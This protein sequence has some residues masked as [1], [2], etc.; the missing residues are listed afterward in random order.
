MAT[1]P[2]TSNHEL[3]LV[4]PIG[5]DNASDFEDIWGSVLNDEGWS[6]LDEK[7]VVRDTFANKD[8]YTAYDGALYWATDEGQP[9]LEGDGGSW[10]VIS[11]E[12]STVVADFLD[13]DDVEATT[14]TVESEPTDSTDA[15]RKAETDALQSELDSL[16]VDKLDESDY[17]PEAD[18]HDRYT[19]SEARTAVDGATVDIA[20]Q[21]DSTQSDL[22]SHTS[23]S[24][25]H[26]GSASEDW[27]SS[28]FNDYAD[29]DA[30]SAVDGATV[31][32]AGQADS[33]QS[34]LD[35]HTSDSNPHSGSASEDWVSSNFNDYTDSEARSALED[36]SPSFDG[37]EVS[38]RFAAGIGDAGRAYAFSLEDNRDGATFYMNTDFVDSGDGFEFRFHDDDSS[39]RN[40]IKF[41]PDDES[42]DIP[43]G[44]LEE[45]G[46]RVATRT[47]T[48]SNFNNYTDSD[49]RS[50]V[51]GA[52]IDIA[53]QADSTQSD[54]DSHTS[55]SN[56]HS[57]SASESWVSSNFNDYTD[58]K[59][60][61]AAPIQTVNGETGDVTVEGFSGSHN[62]LSNVDPADHHEVFEPSDYNPEADTHDRYT[63]SEARTAVDG[64]TID[65]TGEASSTQSD[66]DSHTSDSNPHSGSASESWVSSNFN[67]YADSEAVSAVESESSLGF[68]GSITVDGD[69]SD[70]TTTIW[71][72]SAASITSTLLSDNS[73]SVAGRSVAL[74]G[75][76]NI[77]HGDLTSISEDQHHDKSHDHSESDISAVTNSGL[78]NDSVTVAGNTISLGGSSSIGHGDLNNVGTDNHHARDHDHSEQ[79]VSTVGHQGLEYYQVTVAGNQVALGA[80]T[81]VDHSDLS[82]VS[83]DD[84]HVAH[85]HPGDRSAESDIDVAGN[86]LSNV[87]SISGQHAEHGFEGSTY[88]IDLQDSGTHAR[89]RNTDG[90]SIIWFRDDGDVEIPNGSLTIGGGLSGISASDIGALDVGDY[91]PE[92]DTH[93]RYTNSEASDAAP[94][95]TVNGKTGNVSLDALID[96]GIVN[97]TYPTK[98]DVPSDLPTGTQVWVEEDDTLYVEDGS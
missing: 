91:N 61:D 9:V 32:I 35:S 34:D 28:N 95:Q 78:A 96:D 73:V 65:I 16:D 56:P 42:V 79:G 15:A 12:F 19:D 4:P 37:I 25:P 57:E 62:D 10:S 29:S 98:S 58:F 31:D 22:D 55:D 68:S 81:S 40:A 44:H 17:N 77:A 63:D 85:E 50:A 3:P 64:A 7:L 71:D 52:T 41:F 24:N 87:E 84:H 49:A 5:E 30:R 18:T 83:D 46:D 67:D 6:R 20:G 89:Y 80:S 36:S 8:N 74:G 59:A 94:V 27:V 13:V 86:E 76:T 23:D 26:S 92:A 82:G 53:G 33:T 51:D 21:A 60:S 66:L 70:G 69:I 2:T 14:V 93:D 11:T 43:N 90:D 54:L 72:S 48:S 38:D 39:F 88:N 75:S 45:Q 47:W 1:P 97:T